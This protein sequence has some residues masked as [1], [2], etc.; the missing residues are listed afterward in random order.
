MGKKEEISVDA[1]QERVSELESESAGKDSV[2]ADLQEELKMA[3]K[4]GKAKGEVG[5]IGK[6]RYEVA[7]GLNIPGKAIY[8]A[9][10]IADDE[11]LL[12]FCVESGF[13]NVKE[14]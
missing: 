12:K 9:K 2:I 1:L 11:E 7:Y 4:V 6:K 10:Q 14:L 3:G 5:K 8:T 13:E